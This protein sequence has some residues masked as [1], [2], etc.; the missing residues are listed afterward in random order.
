MKKEWKT[1]ELEILNVSKTM[2]GADGE[3]TDA[4][5]PRDTPKGSITFH[6]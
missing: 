5:F 2:L 3:F 1:P 6:S 4:A